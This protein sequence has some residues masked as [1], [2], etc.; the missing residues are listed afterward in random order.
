MLGLSLMAGCRGSSDAPA[1]ATSFQLVTV[2][3]RL[4][5]PWG[6]AFLPDGRMLV[7]ERAGHARLV[8]ADGKLGPALRGL[9]ATID[10][11]G[12]GGLLD[13][14]LDPDFVVNRR[15]YFSFSEKGAGE[16][17][18]LNS[19]AVWRAELNSDATALVKGLVIF[20][21]KPKV[22]SGG[23]FGGRLVFDREKALFLTL[24]DRQS[25]SVDAQDAGNHLGKVVR[26]T[27]DGK[28]APGNPF[29]GRAGAAPEIWSIGHRNVQGAALHPATGALWTHEH[30]PQGG[31]EVNLTQ[32]GRNYGWP[33]I[34]HGCTYGLCQKIGEGI[35][36][37]GMEQ[38][39]TWWPKP[40][41]A[42]SGM[43]FY[44]GDRF[45]AWKGSVFVGALAGQTLWRL[46]LQ[47]SKVVGRESLLDGQGYRVR[48]VLQ[49][50]DGWLYLL[51]DEPDG[52]IL[53]LQ[54]KA[55]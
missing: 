47:G 25:R 20:T 44:T 41:T 4:A 49:G 37:Q 9:P 5:H 50:P 48:T 38:P 35:A 31:D 40:S 39:L 33:V 36:R 23:H 15:V 43:A 42:P 52:K 16:D 32:P 13:V 24:G 30:G 29:A 10:V 22:N 3:S 6:L 21:Q 12:Q 34:T 45:P 7:S 53:R 51:T 46:T 1:A 8:S 55:R 14:V 26:I 2:A 17:R 27:T 11:G 18:G 19:T 54:A 28:P